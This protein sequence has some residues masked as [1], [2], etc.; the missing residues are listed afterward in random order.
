[1]CSAE[2]IPFLDLVAPHVEL[3]Q[4]LTGVFRRALYTAGFI[5]GPVVEEFEHSFAKFCNTRYSIAVSSGTDALRFAL[6]ACGVQSGDVVVTVPHTFI[7]TTEA[8]SQ[9]GAIPEFV[10]IDE[11]T[12]NIS[13]EKLREFLEEKC[14]RDTSG[15]LISC[16]SHRRVRAIVPVHL[17]GQMADMDP[18][19]NLAEE[20]GVTVVEDACQAHGGEYFSA[21]RNQWMTAGSMGCAAAFSF[22]PGKNLGACGEA[23]GV[24][25]NDPEI[26]GKIR[27]LRDHGQAR[28][29]YHDVE[30]Y[31]GRLDAIQAGLLQAKLAHLAKWNLQRRELAAEY[32]R[33]LANND[34]VV[35][36]YEPFW[37]RAVY[38][39]YVIRVN[40]RDNLM[41]YLKEKGIGT[42][43]HYPLPLHMQK[44]YA[45]LKYLPSDLPVACRVAA[46]VIS[47]PMFPQLTAEQQVRVAED[48]SAFTLGISRLPAEK[49]QVPGLAELTV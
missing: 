21:K 46:E 24:T 32:N 12:Y 8:I 5:G 35:V 14:I 45:W 2:G 16:R 44:A 39:L 34:A 7:A 47:L 19:L 13:A 30:G 23:G 48:I 42:G 41:S 26:A 36:P 11:Q 17:Y 38:H 22:Y 29:Y 25:T 43:I 3:E 31:N 1:M 4:E 18:I 20:Y 27:I 10:D 49:A 28:K 15:D 33:L 40:D 37:S 6:M 9:A